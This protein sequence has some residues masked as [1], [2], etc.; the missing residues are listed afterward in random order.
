MSHS[1]IVLQKENHLDDIIIEGN[2]IHD[3]YTSGDK[4]KSRRRLEKDIFHT[5]IIVRGN[6][7][8]GQVQMQ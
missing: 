5:N 8:K 1:L 6:K 3:V 4:S 7:L 2:Y